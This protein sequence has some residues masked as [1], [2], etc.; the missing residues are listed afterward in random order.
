MGKPIPTA[1]PTAAEREVD[2][3]TCNQLPSG[4]CLGKTLRLDALESL[5]KRINEFWRSRAMP[6]PQEPPE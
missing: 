5:V 1:I 2:I 6:P 3:L 4:G